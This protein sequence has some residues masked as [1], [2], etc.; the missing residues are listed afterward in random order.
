MLQFLFIGGILLVSR[1]AFIGATVDTWGSA[2][3][4]GVGSAIV[5]Y[6][7]YLAAATMNS[8][9]VASVLA[10]FLIGGVLISLLTADNPEWWQ[11]HFS[12]LGAGS[13]VSRYAFN[14]TLIFAGL[15][16]AGLSRYIVDDFATIQLK[17][18]PDKQ[19][20]VTTLQVLLAT[21]GIMLACVGLFVY[22]QF[23]PIH[24]IAAFG[25]AVVFIMTI[26]LLPWIT[27]MLPTIL[28]VLSYS[29]GAAT[30]FCVWLFVGIG[31]L[32][33]IIFELLVAAIVFIWLILFARN[34]SALAAPETVTP[35]S[36]ERKPS[37]P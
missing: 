6:G 11:V 35:P 28:C 3:I 32:N 29:F 24:N 1:N 26:V 22:D 2:T 20:K 30:I 23:P 31:Y 21:L 5:A 9:R 17:K 19:L 13:G 37:R 18:S 27:P 36:A 33:L 25:M 16:V 10:Q 8:Q 12:S 7:A 4:I 14:L 15:V 34:I